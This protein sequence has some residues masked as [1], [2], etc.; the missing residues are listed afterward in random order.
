MKIPLSSFSKLWSNEIMIFYQY[1]EQIESLYQDHGGQVPSLLPP[2]QDQL[3]V[4]LRR[5]LIIAP[6][7]DDECLMAG[8][9]LRAKRELGSQVAVL[10][11]SFG[12]ATERQAA[13]ELELKRALAVLGFE[14]SNPRPA[15]NHE[16]LTD[17]EVKA[18]FDRFR[19]D[20]ILIPHESD[21]HPAHIRCAQAVKRAASAYCTL[22][23][24]S[25]S[26]FE[27]EYWQS[28]ES[29]NLLIPLNAGLVSILGEALMQHEGEVS[30]NP[31]HLTLPAWYMDQERRGRERV[32]G[33][34]MRH[35]GLGA[36]Q[37]F[38][39]V[40]SQLYRFYSITP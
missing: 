33:L 38:H 18:T 2:L 39:S 16:E 37:A 28:M 27:S 7:P 9:A 26:V 15:G 6:H 21:A 31:Y 30:R 40:F 8:L 1:V 32:Y 10:P 4:S 5:I 20:A 17:Q 12:S 34:G 29:P 3:A 22:N 35:G 36:R 14:S 19:P 24:L 13:R 23:K 11:F 25:L